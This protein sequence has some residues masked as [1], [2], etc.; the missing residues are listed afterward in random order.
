MGRIANTKE[1]IRSL[2]AKTG[3]QCAFPGCNH[4]LVE[5][6]DTYVA[7]KCHIEAANFG[8]PR[9]NA[10]M[11]DEERRAISNLIVLCHRHH[12]VTDDEE[13]FTVD[14]MKKMKEDHEKLVSDNV[15]N[16]SDSALDAII[17]EQEAFES[18]VLQ[19][20]EKW[21][22]EFDLAME[23]FLLKNPLDH[24]QEMRDSIDKVEGL[25]DEVHKFLSTLPKDIAK[26][27]DD[28]GYDST[29]YRKVPCYKN[30]FY[31]PFWEMLNIGM[32]NFR[33]AIEFH[34]KALLLHLQF[35]RL[36][37][38]PKDAS[39]RESVDKLK[40]ELADMA[41]TLFHAD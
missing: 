11:T 34:S 1:E 8:G 26:F 24:F 6:D 5:E 10:A 25:V 39:I 20:N 33:S 16:L 41:S 19:K 32:P 29:D 37:S 14:D 38:S 2:F 7:Q 23:A 30:P 17:M 13:K 22:K 40:E 36:Q 27:L 18:D 4:P 21:R 9:Y 3:N 35:Q 15:F 12:K 31:N 28:I